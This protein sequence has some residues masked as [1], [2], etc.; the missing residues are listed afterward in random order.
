M[1]L[2]CFFSRVRNWLATCGGTKRDEGN[3]CNSPSLQGKI[4]KLLIPHFQKN[5]VSWP[6]LRCLKLAFKIQKSRAKMFPN[7]KDQSN[8]VSKARIDHPK[9]DGLYQPFIFWDC[10]YCLL[11]T[12][13]LLAFDQD[14]SFSG[15]C[16]LRT[17]AGDR[18]ALPTPWGFRILRRRTWPS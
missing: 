14:F 17:G 6:E 5:V 2:V 10:A 13:T 7:Q 4:L 3:H 15:C 16:V 11:L 8:T 18:G 1:L 12:I 9:N